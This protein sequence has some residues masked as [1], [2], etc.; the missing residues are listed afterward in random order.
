MGPKA[1]IARITDLPA[2]LREFG[3]RFLADG[4]LAFPYWQPDGREDDT[5]SCL[6]KSVYDTQIL[7]SFFVLQLYGALLDQYNLQIITKSQF[8]VSL[9]EGFD[10][11][12]ALA[13]DTVNKAYAIN[14]NP[15][16]QHAPLVTV[17]SDKLH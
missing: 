6:F 16:R 8:D 17:A 3:E 14:G 15:G 9:G 10:K 2:H 13:A 5:L 11:I 12:T 1:P 7:S 4:T